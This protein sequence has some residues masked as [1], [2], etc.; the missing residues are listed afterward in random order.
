MPPPESARDLI[1]RDRPRPQA[2]EYANLPTGPPD[3]SNRSPLRREFGSLVRAFL[4]TTADA[5]V[6]T[7][8]VD[9]RAV[10]QVSIP[11]QVNKLAGPGNS[12]DRIEVVVDQQTGFPV[13]VTESLAGRAL[14]DA[15]LSK[16]SIDAPVT[17][18]SFALTFP[19]GAT[20]F[21]QDFGFQRTTID[22][23]SA[24][25]GYRPILP[26]DLP[27]GF[28]LA[29]LT[30]ARQSQPTGAEGMNPPG[31]NVV[32]AVYRRGF[33]RIVV[34]TR[35][36]GADPSV[37]ED[38]VATG[39]GIRDEPQ[40]LAIS[41]GALAGARANLVLTPRGI[42]HVWAINSRFVVTVAGDATGAELTRIV[43]SFG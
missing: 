6:T 30:V 20:P 3:Y 37:W 8:T 18:A 11:V 38:P 1:T 26:S 24:V 17:P 43:Q 34:T 28:T 14:L 10:W 29:D 42:P 41:A 36:T 7:A 2:S 5:P 21:R 15:R 27:S 39:E 9:G 31:R 33:D 16:L 4:D 40:P 25:V 23:A 12:G 32:S 22:Q 13:R 35:L 19:P